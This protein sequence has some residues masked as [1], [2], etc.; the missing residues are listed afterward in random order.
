MDC[1]CSGE[2][3]NVS[4]AT[5]PYVSSA[6]SDQVLKCTTGRS[7]VGT[8]EWAPRDKAGAWKF[9]LRVTA[10]VEARDNAGRIETTH[11][12]KQIDAETGGS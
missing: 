5:S 1:S 7:T 2:A 11:L 10:M 6:S 12:Y 9:P 8:Y 3:A 4:G